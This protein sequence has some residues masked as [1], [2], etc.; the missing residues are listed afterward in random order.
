MSAL[1]EAAARH[2]DAL[3]R[4][5]LALLCREQLRIDD[6]YQKVPLSITTGRRPLNAGMQR[7][8]RYGWLEGGA[9]DGTR[10]GKAYRTTAAGRER[11]MAL[12]PAAMKVAS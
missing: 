1:S 12:A 11:L 10:Y 7:M 9:G 6:I 4:A 2:R 3:D 5:V 8:L